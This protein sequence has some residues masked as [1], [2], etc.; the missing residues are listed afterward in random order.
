MRSK[1]QAAPAIDRSGGNDK[2]IQIML[3]SDGAP[4]AGGSANLSFEATPFANTQDLVIEWFIPQGVAL[5]G[6]ASETFGPQAAGATVHVERVLSFPTP[7]TYKIAVTATFHQ[8]PE[9]AFSAAGVLFFV[10]DGA[11]SLG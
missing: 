9:A 7:G 5:Q 8:G 4:A 2:Y 1:A 6:L 3:K 10:I 11:G